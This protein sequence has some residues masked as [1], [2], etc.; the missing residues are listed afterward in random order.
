MVEADLGGE[1]MAH[2]DIAIIGSGL[3]GLNLVKEIR[4]IDSSVS[5]AVFT[6]EDGHFYSKPMLS[7]ALAKNKTAEQLPIQQANAFAEQF[8]VSLH[9]Q[10]NI[11]R[12]DPNEKTLT[13]IDGQVFTWNKLVLAQGASPIMLKDIGVQVEGPVYTVNQLSEYGLFRQ[14]LSEA[15]ERL[16]GEKVRVGIIGSGL[17]GCEFA[18][19]LADQGYVVSILDIANRPMPRM[20]SPLQSRA[21]QQALADRGVS[22][23]LEQKVEAI[24]T[25]QHQS[26]I[27]TA[28]GLS[29]TVDV[30]LSAVGLKPCDQV[31]KAAGLAVSRGVQVNASLESSASDVFALGDCA[32][33]EGIRLQ[34]VLPLMAC[35]RALAKTL[36]GQ[37]TPVT[38]PA[39]PVV[40]KTP[41]LPTV[42]AVPPN[43]SFEEKDWSVTGE[44][45]NLKAELKDASGQTVGF[46]LT[47]QCVSEKN[48]LA[49]TIPPWLN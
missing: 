25:D 46:A 28:D 45:P 32:A 5:I 9:S 29:L 44:A 10:V 21:L 31:A 27:R 11:E 22:W 12:F 42:L 14:A 43:L 17:V 30:V 41:A 20:L 16:Q 33:I 7:N 35:A 40:V 19:D 47:G 49:K 3:A 18:N 38:F 39:M 6:S 26:I 15:S 13:T 37:P 34:Y 1:K 8:Q 23:H 36:T 2:S 48:A 24:E 4:K